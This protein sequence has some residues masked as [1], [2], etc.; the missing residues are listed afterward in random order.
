MLPVKVHE[1]HLVVADL[2][3]GE[4]R[5]NR[6]DRPWIELLGPMLQTGENK[7]ALFTGRRLQAWLDEVADRSQNRLLPWPKRE[8]AAVAAGRVLAELTLSLAE[9]NRVGARAAQD[10]L[11]ELLPAETYR[12]LFP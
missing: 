9:E 3:S 8:A 10:K 4:T 1:P 5:L 11:R 2:P 6:E 12:L 7:N